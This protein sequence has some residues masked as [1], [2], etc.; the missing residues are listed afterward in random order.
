MNRRW[1]ATAER[2]LAGAALGLLLAWGVWG[3]AHDVPRIVAGIPYVVDYVRGMFPPDVS[4]LPDLVGPLGE[5]LQ[6]AVA[7]TFFSAMLA[8]PLSLLAARNTAPG[9]TVYFLVRTCIGLLRAI[10]T[11]LWA[12]LFVA[13]VGLGPL[14]GLLALTCHC[15]GALGKYFAEA[16]EAIGPK[17]QEVLEAMR[18]DGANEVQVVRYGLFPAAAPLLVGYIL[19]YFEYNVRVGTVLGLVGAGGLGLQ[20]LMAVRLFRR[21]ETLTI[22]L[23]ILMAVLLVDRVSWLIRRGLNE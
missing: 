3:A 21:Q 19:Y 6:M 15:V 20:L 8:L 12:I 7:A 4:V 18:L 13:F 2:W 16:L 5:T 14:A 10:P 17:M 1:P 22:I 9:P 23:V 11:F